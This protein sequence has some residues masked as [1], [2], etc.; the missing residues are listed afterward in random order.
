MESLQLPY[1]MEDTLVSSP[2]SPHSNE[3]L[4]LLNNFANEYLITNNEI[5]PIKSKSAEEILMELEQNISDEPSWLH[6]P[7]LD[8]GFDNFTVLNTVQEP[9]E[10]EQEEMKLEKDT[11]DLLNE[12][13]NV[14]NAVGLQ[15]T[16]PATPPPSSSKVESLT[17]QDL[18]GAPIIYIITNDTSSDVVS[19]TQEM[20]IDDALSE[21]NESSMEL[22]DELVREH[23]FNIP[24]NFSFNLDD[25]SIS[26]G[27]SSLSSS[28]PSFSPRSESDASSLDSFMSPRSNNSFD[29]AGFDEEWTPALDKAAVKRTSLKSATSVT[30]LPRQKRP[31]GRP[32]HEKKQRKKEQN[33]NA[34]TRYRQ[35]KKEQ[36]VEVLGIEEKLLGEH[37]KLQIKYNDVK[38]EISYLK[39]L[40]KEVFIAKGIHV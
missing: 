21:T 13:E 10:L 18:T 11:A 26:N 35:K 6:N 2:S 25:D 15:L 38:R 23:S 27:S 24:E 14:C 39:K 16:P 32:L 9:I 28:E 19:P 4:M 31:Y 22:I 34:A 36:L 17:V 30:T 20:L 7:K 12:F 40:M 29:T 33:K 8:F 3:E 1:W 5:D 37:Q